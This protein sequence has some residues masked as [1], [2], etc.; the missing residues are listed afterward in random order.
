MTTGRCELDLGPM[1]PDRLHQFQRS[2][3]YV[4]ARGRTQY[5]EVY[6]IIHPGQVLAHPRGVRTTPW[7]ERFLDHGAEL[8][9]SA[10]WERGQW[11]RANDALPLPG[12]MPRRSTWAERHWS[13]TIGREHLA[14]RT[15]VGVFD[16][17]PFVKVEAE[18]PG[19]VDRLNRVCASE[20]DRPVGR[21]LYT[22]VLDHD[23]GCVCD[24]TV[25][26]LAE[27]RYRRHGWR[28]R[29]S[30]RRLAAGRAA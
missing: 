10:G 12:V 9:E 22:T 23:A 30:R 20:M 2:P 25:T 19:V 15:G 11:F 28:L 3:L 14:T 26:R 29:A 27:E 4:K 7:H 6:D 13:P 17:T 1:H 18:G 5:D 24:L 16:L 21:M 8:T